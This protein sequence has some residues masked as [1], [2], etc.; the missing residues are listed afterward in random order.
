M[1]LDLGFLF[2]IMVLCS[3]LSR[4]D[5][6]RHIVI[7]HT[8]LLL[9]HRYM[10]HK[11]KMKEQSERYTKFQSSTNNILD[12]AMK[13]ITSSP[14]TEDD[15]FARDVV[16]LETKRS[17]KLSDLFTYF[18]DTEQ[19]FF[20]CHEIRLLGVDVIALRDINSLSSEGR[21]FRT[22]DSLGSTTA[23][24]PSDDTHY[25]V[26]KPSPGHLKRQKPIIRILHKSRYVLFSGLPEH[27][28]PEVIQNNGYWNPILYSSYEQHPLPFKAC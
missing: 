8:S 14:A 12:M 7:S 22:L 16:E 9:L 11:G 1:R 19:P 28:L 26:M 6:N 21:H 20:R 17:A 4:T 13:F 5:V 27:P 15:P 25:K 10:Y 18:I 23:A 3:N 24:Y 2:G